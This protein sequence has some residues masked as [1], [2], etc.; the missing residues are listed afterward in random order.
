MSF[1]QILILDVWSTNIFSCFC[2]DGWL[3]FEAIALFGILILNLYF[4]NIDDNLKHKE[5]IIK[6][7]SVL[8][9]IRGKPKNYNWS[10]TDI[11]FLLDFLHSYLNSLVNCTFITKIFKHTSGMLPFNSESNQNDLNPNVTWCAFGETEWIIDA[12]GYS[13]DFHSYEVDPFVKCST[14]RLYQWQPW[15]YMDE[16]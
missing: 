14:S 9:R 8:K 1:L 5:H 7:K 12:Y 16:Q 13:Q 3:V 6:A 4:L 11:M 2:R 10:I 15:V